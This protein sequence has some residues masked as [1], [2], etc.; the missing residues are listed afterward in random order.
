MLPHVARHFN[1]LNYSIHNVTNGRFLTN[2][3]IRHIGYSPAVRS[4]LGKI[5]LK[6]EGTVFPNTDRPRQVNNIFIFFFYNTTKG[7]RKTRTL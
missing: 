3:L 5:V 2:L 4:V 1:L 7:V 6:T